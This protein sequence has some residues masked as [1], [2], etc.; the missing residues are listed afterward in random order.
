[1]STKEPLTAT[2]SGRA[3]QLQVQNSSLSDLLTVVIQ[4]RDHPQR[5]VPQLK[6]FEADGFECS[7]VIAD[8]TE[9]GEEIASQKARA[10]NG[11]AY[12]R[13]N[14]GCTIFDKLE[15]VLASVTTPFVLV[16][17]GPKNYV[18][19]CRRR[20]ARASHA[21]SRSCRGLGLCVGLSQAGFGHQH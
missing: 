1:M 12:R 17:P 15:T 10:G 5:V 20:C 13:F 2:L 9:G 18:L 4:T 11:I 21:A 3:R 14:P 19:A 16:I 6:M 8:S 7:I